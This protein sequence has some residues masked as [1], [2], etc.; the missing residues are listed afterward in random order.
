MDRGNVEEASGGLVTVLIREQVPDKV[1]GVVR[2]Y[3]VCCPAT[4]LFVRR[5][6]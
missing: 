5:L 1:A 6:P 4:A 3:R 2:D